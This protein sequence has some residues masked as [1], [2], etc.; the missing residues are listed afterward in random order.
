[1]TENIR[2]LSVRARNALGRLGC[3]TAQ[4]VAR[5]SES[6]LL[7]LK[8]VGRATVQEIKA[9]MEPFNLALSDHDWP[10]DHINPIRRDSKP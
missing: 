5:Y 8:N 4:D 7:R 10:A 2:R 6:D 1:V 3:V 9:W